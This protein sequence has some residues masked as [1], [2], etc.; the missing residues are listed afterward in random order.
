MTSE[1]KSSTYESRSLSVTFK[2]LDVE[3][4]EFEFRSVSVTFGDPDVEL[5]KYEFRLLSVTGD[6]EVELTK[7]E[8]RSV[9]VTGDPDVELT[10]YECR[11]VPVTFEDPDVELTSCRHSGQTL[12]LLSQVF[13]HGPWNTCPQLGPVASSSLCNSSRQIAHT[14]RL[15]CLDISRVVNLWNQLFFR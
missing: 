11:S 12:F 7:Y 4:T 8:C 6:P 1:E 3:L 15:P 9:P 5:T 14:L 2:D 13:K 10:E